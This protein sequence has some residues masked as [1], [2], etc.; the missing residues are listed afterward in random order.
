MSGRT[1][2]SLT[3]ERVAREMV[4][5]GIEDVSMPSV[6]QYMNSYIE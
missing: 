5:Q 2:E 4:L 1:G 6:S 3:N